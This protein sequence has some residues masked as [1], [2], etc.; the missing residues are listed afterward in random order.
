MEVGLEG[1]RECMGLGSNYVTAL[2]KWIY[3]AVASGFEIH[4]F[5]KQTLPSLWMN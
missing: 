1:F 3:K 4:S 2:I 5:L